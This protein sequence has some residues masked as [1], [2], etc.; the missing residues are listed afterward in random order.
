MNSSSRRL[1][2]QKRKE[3]DW[4]KEG[5]KEKLQKGR[6]KERE[7]KTKRLNEGV[8]V[9]RKVRK[10]KRDY[11][12]KET[13]YVQFRNQGEDN[14]F[15]KVFLCPETTLKQGKLRVYPYIW[16]NLKTSLTPEYRHKF[17]KVS[18]CISMFWGEHSFIPEKLKEIKNQS[19]ATGSV[20]FQ[21][22]FLT[23]SMTSIYLC[24]PLIPTG[25]SEW[26]WIQA[27][28]TTFLLPASA[29]VLHILVRIEEW[30]YRVISAA[31][32]CYF[33]V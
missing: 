5:K 33:C 15:L 29:N 2:T 10:S 11:M 3:R 32:V 30:G 26:D 31:F 13:F 12:P 18:R 20:F 7:R 6:K 16:L 19:M 14:F 17:W 8:K 28:K 1:I 22:L 23:P 21:E 25:K 24:S 4:R 9:S 27:G